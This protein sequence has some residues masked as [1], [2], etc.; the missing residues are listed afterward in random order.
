M[1]SILEVPF[2]F[3]IGRLGRRNRIFGAVR[4][5]TQYFGIIG[6]RNLRLK[7]YSKREK[8]THNNMGYA[9]QAYNR[10][11]K[12]SDEYATLIADFRRQE[13]YGLKHNKPYC[14]TPRGYFIS[15]Y[16][17]GLAQATEAEQA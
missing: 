1:K 3:L 8:Q 11:D 13:Q 7:P 6:K 4:Y 9:S 10:L 14:K 15:S 2:R 17:R 16:I 5:G 12:S